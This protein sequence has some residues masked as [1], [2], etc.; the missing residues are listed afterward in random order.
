MGSWPVLRLKWKRPPYFWRIWQ[1][2]RNSSNYYLSIRYVLV[3]YLLVCN[4]MCR[5]MLPHHLNACG[6]FSDTQVAHKKKEIT[7]L[8]QQ[9]TELESQL[10]QI[11]QKVSLIGFE[12]LMS[13]GR[14]QKGSIPNL[15]TEGFERL[16]SIQDALD[17]MT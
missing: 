12:K 14:L 1:C 5:S 11:S 10:S 6:M 17:D 9:I 7:S 4:G 15:H 13:E 16:L 8:T 3:H 2:H